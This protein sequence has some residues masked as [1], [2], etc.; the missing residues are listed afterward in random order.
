ML[1]RQYGLDEAGNAGGRVEM[2]DVRLGGADRTELRAFG[3]A[4]A[5][6]LRQ[7]GDFDGVAQLRAG[8]VG[9]DVGD[10]VGV[11]VGH[12]LG[13][14]DGFGLA[15]DAGRGNA[16]L[17]HAVIVDGRALDHRMNMVAVG[18]RVGQA[19]EYH[20]ADAVAADCALGLRVEGAAFSVRRKHEA[21]RI[22]TSP[23]CNGRTACQHDVGLIAEQAL[24]RHIDGDQRGRAGCLHGHR[25][26]G[27][28][29]LV[30]GP[31]CQE[32][33]VCRGHQLEQARRRHDLRAAQQAVQEVGAQ[34]VAGVDPDAPAVGLRVVAGRFQCLPRALQHDALLRVGDLGIAGGEVEEFRIE[35]I[36]VFQRAA[37]RDEVGVIQ[38][39]GRDAGLERLRFGKE[40]DGF[41]AVLQV[42]P[43]FKDIVGAGKA[44]RHADDGDIEAL[45]GVLLRCRVHVVNP[46]VWG[47]V[48][49]G[50]VSGL[51][52]RP[53]AGHDLATAGGPV[54]RAGAMRRDDGPRD[55]CPRCVRQAMR[56][57]ETG[58]A[59]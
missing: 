8:A 36:L 46:G 44:P 24:A 53:C 51:A 32:V 1:D 18:Q 57:W 52:R 35:V 26:A 47:W 22:D 12:G 59:P 15:A 43:V 29:E 40:P 33:L 38:H 49:E 48:T 25:G 30:G 37:C 41:H 42:F 50:R 17:A 27:Q 10:R 14:E 7:R 6:G 16:D 9:L 3:A 34:A 19:L 23:R 28:V 31:R 20:E 56:W 54:A 4:A 11:D 5:E 2:A 45:G 55:R 39:L 58:T 13:V 21:F